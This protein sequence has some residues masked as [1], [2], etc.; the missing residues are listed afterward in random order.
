MCT[1]VYK[2][3]L[4]DSINLDAIKHLLLFYSYFLYFLAEIKKNA[5]LFQEKMGVLL[6]LRH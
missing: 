1:D 4:D 5:Q 3:P 2:N 6:I